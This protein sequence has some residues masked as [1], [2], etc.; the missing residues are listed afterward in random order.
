MNKTLKPKLEGDTEALDLNNS[1]RLKHELKV[2][3]VPKAETQA[4]V[5]KTS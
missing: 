3:A 4:K 2:K 1:K 5:F